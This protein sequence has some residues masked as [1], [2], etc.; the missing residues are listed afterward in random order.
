MASPAVSAQCAVS[1]HHLQPS[2]YGKEL[3]DDSMQDD[4]VGSDALLMDVQLKIDTKSELRAAGYQQEIGE[5]TM[6]RVG[7]GTPSMPVTKEVANNG[8]RKA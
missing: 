2:E 1:K 8:K 6:H 3:P 5:G 7:K 4:R